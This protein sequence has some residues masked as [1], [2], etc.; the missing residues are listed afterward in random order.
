LTVFAGR[1]EMASSDHNRLL[2]PPQLE[3]IATI[4]EVSEPDD[5]VKLGERVEQALQD[6]GPSIKN[7]PP[8][9]KKLRRTFDRL[10][11]TARQLVRDLEELGPYE[12]REFHRAIELL[13]GSR[14]KGRE[15]IDPPKAISMVER[16]L[17]TFTVV[18]RNLP[19]IR[20]GPPRQRARLY[21]VDRLRIVYSQSRTQIESDGTILFEIPRRAR[22]SELK[23]DYGRFKDF[24]VAALEALEDPA[25]LQGIDDVIRVVCEDARNK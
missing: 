9:P 5:M 25:L 17:T 7:P 2:K 23:C 13:D 15:L 6:Y 8:S 18:K 16:I 11:D 10:S 3:Q 14:P 21:L 22:N 1:V 12:Q 19:P 24:V 20:R 4:L